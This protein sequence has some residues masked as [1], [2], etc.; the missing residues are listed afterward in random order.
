MAKFKF[1]LETLL[2]LRGAA[3]DRRRQ[4]LAE[5]YRVEELIQREQARVEEDMGELT[6]QSREACGPGELNLDRLLDARRYELVLRAQQKFLGRQQEA[7]ETQIEKR[8]DALVEAS[9]GVRVLEL[10]R[11]K[12]D[13]R[14]QEQENRQ[15]TKQLD[16]VAGRR[17]AR[18]EA[19]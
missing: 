15:L 11:E 8:R 9:R 17:R 10:L 18:E 3:R 16:D 4:E 1:R 6:R 14:H 19:R 13:R 5:A 12:L 7:V 2:R